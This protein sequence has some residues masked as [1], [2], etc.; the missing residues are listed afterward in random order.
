MESSLSPFLNT[1]RVQPATSHYIQTNQ[2][3]Q[4]KHVYITTSPHLRDSK[5][6]LAFTVN[7]IMLEQTANFFAKPAALQKT[8]RVKKLGL[9]SVKKFHELLDEISD[10]KLLVVNLIKI[11][12]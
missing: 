11:S 4:H 12:N 1:T 3:D 7:R 2:S 5:Q 6:Y 9:L 10:Q 8:S